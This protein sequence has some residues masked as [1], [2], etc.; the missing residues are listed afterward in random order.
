LKSTNIIAD[1]LKGKRMQRESRFTEVIHF[2]GST[3]AERLVVVELAVLSA[4]YFFMRHIE[5]FLLQS[6]ASRRFVENCFKMKRFLNPTQVALEE[7]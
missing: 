7:F 4:H 3:S 2:A 6:E 5:A 1:F